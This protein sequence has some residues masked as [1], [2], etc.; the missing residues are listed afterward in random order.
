MK[1]A[2]VVGNVVSIVKDA[3]YH[4]YKL[5]IVSYLGEDR[6]EIAFDGANAGVGDIVL[7]V[8]DGGACNLVLGDHEVIVDVTI[9]GVVDHFDLEHGERG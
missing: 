4:G 9:C 1:L 2:K 5:M 8:C 6:H 3:T 7:V